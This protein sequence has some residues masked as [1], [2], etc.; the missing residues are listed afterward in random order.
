MGDC[1]C[2][3]LICYD[4]KG[5]H[6]L[7]YDNLENRVKRIYDEYVVESGNTTKEYLNCIKGLKGYLGKNKTQEITKMISDGNFGMPF[8]FYLRIITIHCMVIPM[9]LTRITASTLTE[10]IP[11]RLP[12]GSPLT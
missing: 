8:E 10:V 3:S 1:F 2:G 7:I 4:E 12:K 9:V 5:L 6:V 11:V